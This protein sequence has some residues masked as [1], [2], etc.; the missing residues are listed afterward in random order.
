MINLIVLVLVLTTCN[1]FGL[2]TLQVKNLAI[3]K[4]SQ[5]NYPIEVVNLNIVLE[6][7]K[8]KVS[9]TLYS[10]LDLISPISAEVHVK[11]RVLGMWIPLPCVDLMG[12]CNYLDLCKYG[13]PQ[14]KECDRTFK[15]NK[16][17]CRCPIGK[18]NYTINPTI[19]LKPTKSIVNNVETG[20]YKGS[21][22]VK[23]N[24]DLLACYNF[25]FELFEEKITDPSVNIV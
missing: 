18:G 11:R 1:T 14:E 13:V 8:A 6:N 24:K 23:I 15:E 19:D 10:S 22:T 9:G 12:S 17:P 16:V 2:K 4:C 3:S 21:A 5:N 7:S 25:N 20:R